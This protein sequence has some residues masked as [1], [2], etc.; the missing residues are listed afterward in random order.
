MIL[1]RSIFQS[2]F[3]AA[4]HHQDEPIYK[5]AHKSY[6]SEAFFGV[7]ESISSL[8]VKDVIVHLSVIETE[9]GA[10]SVW[11]IDDRSPPAGIVVG[12]FLPL[13]KFD[14]QEFG[15]PFP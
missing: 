1:E 8:A 12:K 5:K 10:V 13:N 2:E 4:H 14:D 15:V 6:R 7:E 3:I 9:Q 11:L